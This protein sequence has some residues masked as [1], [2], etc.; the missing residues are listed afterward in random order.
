M[1]FE[2]PNIPIHDG[3]HDG[4]S[5][6]PRPTSNSIAK[7]S[8]PDMVCDLGVYPERP[9]GSHL[10]RRSRLLRRLVEQR[11]MGSIRSRLEPPRA[12]LPASTCIPLVYL[13]DEGQ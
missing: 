10:L 5:P 1:D 3:V 13:V 8:P 12:Q 2:R 9:R 4:M 7:I 11:L 6:F